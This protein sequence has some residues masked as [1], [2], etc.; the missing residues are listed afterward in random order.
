MN[1]KLQKLCYKAT[2]SARERGHG[3]LSIKHEYGNEYA[4]V[5]CNFCGKEARVTLHPRP[6]E[7]DI[8]GELVAVRCEK[9]RKQNPPV[10]TR[11]INEH[12]SDFASA[13]DFLGSK[14]EVALANNTRLVRVRDTNERPDERA[15]GVKL[16][17]TYV[18]T[19]YEGGDIEVDFGGYDTVTTRQRI[20]QLLPHGLGLVSH[21]GERWLAQLRADGFDH[22]HWER[23]IK[24]SGKPVVVR[25]DDEPYGK[26]GRWVERKG[27]RSNPPKRRKL[28]R[29]DEVEVAQHYERGESL[30][31]V[32]DKATQQITVAEWRDDEVGQMVE[33]GFFK[34]RYYARDAH[35]EPKSVLDYCVEMGIIAP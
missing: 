8:G 27:T 16:H 21:K 9:P 29:R 31:W 32:R 20:N 14:A 2:D 11:K 5:V 35:V 25:R 7:I 1:A 17:S 28:L 22:P 12:V 30:V 33:D 34:G 23:I 3:P 26:M 18:V 15:I 24:M 13:D 19:Y 6:N 4:D 10:R